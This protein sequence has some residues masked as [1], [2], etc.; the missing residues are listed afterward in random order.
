MTY[1]PDCRERFKPIFNAKC[2]EN[3]I[4]DYWDGYLNEKDKEYIK[5]WDI[6]TKD[7]IPSFLAN[8]SDFECMNEV[9]VKSEIEEAGKYDCIFELDT[10]ISEN[11]PKAVRFLRK[12]HEELVEWIEGERDEMIVSM[13]DNMDEEEYNAIRTERDKD[14]PDEIRNLEYNQL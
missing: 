12:L 8:I 6:V 13:I 14:L 11:A 9:F 4:N 5:G 1:I 3:E 2:N 7:I 10:D